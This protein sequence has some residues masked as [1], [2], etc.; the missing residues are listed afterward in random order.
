MKIARLAQLLLLAQCTWLASSMP[1][2]AEFDRASAIQLAASVLKVEVLRA[3]G[4]YSIGS[5]VAV[6]ADLVATNCH[7]TQDAQ[8]IF[9]VRGGQRWRATA[10]ATDM[11]HDLCVL[12]VPDVLARV[13]PLAAADGLTVGQNA[14][15]L[16]YTGGIDLQHS[17]GDIV[18]LFPLDGGRVI[19]LRNGFN[20]GASGGGLFN[21]AKQLIGILTFRLRGGAAHYFAAPAEWLRPLLADNAAFR[22]VGPLD[23]RVLPFWQQP[24]ATLPQFLQQLNSE[25]AAES[26]RA[27][28]IP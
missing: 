16:G 18:G 3:Q 7:V 9:I 24:E 23:K 6:G 12:R 10:Q 19:Q 25:F 14:L 5:G 27:K 1:A 8:T 17:E 26:Q 4:G 13:A 20:S 22:P 2:R 15:A 11:V 21:D 28:P